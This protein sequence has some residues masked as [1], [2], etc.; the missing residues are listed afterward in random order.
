MSQWLVFLIGWLVGGS[1]RRYDN[2][3]VY[4]R[5]GRR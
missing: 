3:S 1:V 4:G 2:G 5:Q